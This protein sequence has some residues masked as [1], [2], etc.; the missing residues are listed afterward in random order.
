MRLSYIKH[1]DKQYLVTYSVR[2]WTDAF[3]KI[4]FVSTPSV[5]LTHN[6]KRL[7]EE[8]KEPILTVNLCRCL[9]QIYAIVP[10]LT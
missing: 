4:P 10:P 5:Y 1:L 7:L 8:M 9:R 3:M 6:L 2:V